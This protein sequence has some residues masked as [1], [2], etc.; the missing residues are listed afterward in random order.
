MKVKSIIFIEC[1][2]NNIK[3]IIN[4]SFIYWKSRKNDISLNIKSKIYEFRLNITH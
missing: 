2:T 4:H 3:E 1:I